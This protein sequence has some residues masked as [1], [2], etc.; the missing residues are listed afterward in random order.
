MAGVNSGVRKR[1][2]DLNPLAVFDPCNNH[3]LSLVSG[4]AAHVN[5]QAL[6][7]FLC[8]GTSV[9]LLFMFNSL[10]E[11]SERQCFATAALITSLFY[12]NPVFTVC[13]G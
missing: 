8:C 4:H 11:C 1:I 7:F 10:V 2:L 13:T 6:T 12:T 3:S 5:V 9:W